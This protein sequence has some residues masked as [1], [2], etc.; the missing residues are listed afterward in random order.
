LLFSGVIACS[1]GSS[2]SAEDLAAPQSEV[3]HYRGSSTWLSPEGEEISS[4]GQVWLRRDL[5]PETDQVIEDL[6]SVDG[7]GELNRYRV[8]IS[9]DEDLFSGTFEESGGTVQITGQL[10]G[11]PWEWEAW[12]ALGVYTDGALEGYYFRSEATLGSDDLV[13]D[14][15]VYDASDVYLVHIVEDL[16]FIDGASWDSDV[17]EL[18]ADADS[19]STDSGG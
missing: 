15:R 16:T 11:S 3:Q 4:P 8:E 9:I 17:A 7:G 2:D 13:L 18:E 14:K 19:A 6:I 1:W 5:R 10:S 12:S